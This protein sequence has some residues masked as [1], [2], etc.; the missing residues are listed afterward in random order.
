MD[1]LSA[2][3]TEACDRRAGMVADSGEWMRLRRKV[4]GVRPSIDVCE[5]VGHFEVPAPVV[6]STAVESARDVVAYVIILINEVYSLENDEARD[7][8]QPG[9]LPDAVQER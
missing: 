4:I 8:P 1:Y 7:A 5:R 3:L 9:H 2:N 6:H